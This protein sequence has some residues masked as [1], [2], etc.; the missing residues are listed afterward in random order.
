VEA[1]KLKRKGWGR[2]RLGDEASVNCG[3]LLP[4]KQKERLAKNSK[5]KG[6]SMSEALQLMV[7]RFNAECE[8]IVSDTPVVEEAA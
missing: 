8:E 7:R 2:P 3:F 4:E 6:M 1:A 5:L